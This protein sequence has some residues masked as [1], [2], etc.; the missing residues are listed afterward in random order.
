MAFRRNQSG[1][2]H[3]QPAVGRAF[4]LIEL[5]VVIAIIAILAAL[6]LPALA[7]AKAAGQTAA[8]KSN[9]R[10]LAIALTLYADDY[11]AYT[12]C[13][14][15]RQGLLWYNLLGPYYYG[16]NAQTNTSDKILDCPAYKGGKGFTFQPGDAPVF[17][18]YGG[19]YGYN[20]FGTASVGY[21][22][23]TVNG[24]DS[25]LGLGGVQ[26]GSVSST[27]APPMSLYK[28]LVPSDMI[29]IADS[30]MMQW[31]VTSF[32]LTLG[33]GGRDVPA[34]HNGGSNVGFCDGHVE[35]IQ[36]KALVAPTA[37][38]RSRWNNDH[39]PH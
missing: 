2:H 32:V 18:W 11:E 36:N 38:A 1:S 28:V 4:T 30:M 37:D 33:D 31:K 8:C 22:Y 14:D 35:I 21:T 26:G 9:V 7:R 20:A 6:L 17:F 15:L 16:N 3:G 12:L 13:A 27:P 23:L 19:S 39:K 29:A 34:R 24:T 25:V 5:L 10:Q